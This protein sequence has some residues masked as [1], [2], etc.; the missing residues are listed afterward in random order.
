MV[1]KEKRRKMELPDEL[2]NIVKDFQ[3]DYRRKHKRNMEP[4]LEH[5][6]G[7]YKEVYLYSSVFPSLG[8]GQEVVAGEHNGL[9]VPLQNLPVT[10]VGW[11]LKGKQKWWYGFGWMRKKELKGFKQYRISY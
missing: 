3:L 7:L 9:W 4:S 11:N 2:W 8:Y 1:G 5:I 10:I 6:D